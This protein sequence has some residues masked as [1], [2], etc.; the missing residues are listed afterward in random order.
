MAWLSDDLYLVCFAEQTG[1]AVVTEAV[2]GLGLAG[3]LLA[4]LVLGGHVLVHEGLLS[5]VSGVAAP[6][7]F[8][9]VGGPAGGVRAAA[10]A[11]SGNLA[12]VPGHRRGHRRARP[13]VRC[14]TVDAGA[15]PQCTLS[16]LGPACG[17]VFSLAVISQ[18][19]WRAGSFVVGCV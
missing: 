10:A 16:S 6:T 5:A 15:D 3:G 1:R 14:G 9:V 13:D 2:A 17:T 7:G 4:E 18:L 11:G 19:L 8:A 12:A